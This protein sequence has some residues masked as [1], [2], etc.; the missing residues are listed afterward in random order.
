MTSN[1]VKPEKY[2]YLHLVYHFTVSYK[3]MLYKSWIELLLMLIININLQLNY[4]L[5]TYITNLH[6]NLI[7]Y[8]NIIKEVIEKQLVVL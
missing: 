4:N 3:D 2:D 7:N 5:I 8:P 6:C 1:T